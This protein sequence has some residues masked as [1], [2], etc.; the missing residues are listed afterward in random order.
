MPNKTS[1]SGR[2][3][4][5][6][7]SEL[8]REAAAVR[9]IRSGPQR[10]SRVDLLSLQFTQKVH[11]LAEGLRD[12]AV[13]EAEKQSQATTRRMLDN[14][15]TEAEKI[16]QAATQ[17]AQ[18]AEQAAEAATQRA[19]QAEQEAQAAAQSM[20]ESDEIVL[21]PKPTF[22]RLGDAPAAS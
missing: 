2:E 20:L 4:S 8:V 3:A 19:Q 15:K 13:E 12:K 22:R 5:S 11:Q 16:V 9:G 21:R 6:E 18:Q 10:E 7:V 17:R 1:T 14:A